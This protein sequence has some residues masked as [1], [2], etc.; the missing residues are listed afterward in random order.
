MGFLDVIPEDKFHHY[1]K[2]W[3][4]FEDASSTGFFDVCA[5]AS[6]TR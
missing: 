4:R 1:K 2:D 5:F 6:S 3:M